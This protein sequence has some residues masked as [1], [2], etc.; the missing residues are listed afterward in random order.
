M[1]IQYVIQCVAACLIVS[2]TS[3]ALAA[4][5]PGP[6]P[7]RLER[8]FRDLDRNGDGR[9]D[10]DEFVER[11]P[12][13][14]RQ[15]RQGPPPSPEGK[16]RRPRMEEIE[17]HINEIVEQRVNEI[18]DHRLRESAEERLPRIFEERM[19]SPLGRGPMSDR[20]PMGRARERDWDRDRDWDRPG[21]SQGRAWAC[22][23]PGPGPEEPQ[24]DRRQ[25]GRRGLGL[26][27]GRRGPRGWRADEERGGP[28][29]RP[30]FH[31]LD[32]DHDGKIQAEEINRLADRLRETLDLR[33]GG[34]ITPEDWDHIARGRVE[35]WRKDRRGDRNP[36]PKDEQRPDEPAKP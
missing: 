9:I 20:G 4:D 3:T 34:A 6:G 32:A 7:E 1:S 12:E 19:Q 11:A 17:R 33:E 30:L 22:P 5:P 10:L 24:V 23:V 14:R 16:A 2:L 15:M 29:Q 26:G 35:K 13:T 8:V 31:M 21:R 25:G 28:R 18:L 36:G 27:Q